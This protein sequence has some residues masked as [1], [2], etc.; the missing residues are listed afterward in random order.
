MGTAPQ[1]TNIVLLLFLVYSMFAVL[2]VQLFALT[3]NG[4]RLGPTASFQDFTNAL[5]LIWQII[6]GDEWMII[7]QDISV[8]EPSCT[9]LFDP[10]IEPSYQGPA[11]SWGDCGPSVSVAVGYCLALKLVCEYMMLNLFIGLILDNFSYI[12]EDVGHQ[13]DDRW[14][15][16]PSLDQLSVLREGFQRYDGGTGHVPITSLHCM[17]CDLGAPLGLKKVQ[18][19]RTLMPERVHLTEM[20]RILEHMIR[21]ELNLC[22]RSTREVEASNAKSLRYQLGLK[23]LQKRKLFLHGVSYEDFFLTV[24]FWRFPQLLPAVVKW[25]R[26][27]RVQ[28]VARQCLSTLVCLHKHGVIHCDL[29][30]RTHRA[31]R[32][33]PSP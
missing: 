19:K 1:L 2:G 25:Q 16:G 7:M 9:L 6:T 10:E 12:T 21:A 26:Q 29:V 14:T 27:E 18:R 3:R 13:E 22:I 31:L 5:F 15:E 23:P 8:V 11:R 28:E 33:E 24:T 32:P 4:A 17:L 20:D 30:R